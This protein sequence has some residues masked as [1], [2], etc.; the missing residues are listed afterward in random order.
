MTSNTEIVRIWAYNV[1]KSGK[2]YKQI[3]RIIE[4][5]MNKINKAMIYIDD[6]DTDGE[7]ADTMQYYGIKLNILRNVLIDYK[8]KH[9][10]DF[11]PEQFHARP[12]TI[13]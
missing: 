2:E 4:S 1:I 8:A 5:K 6:N 9:D 7:Q 13:G 11:P 12:E 3:I 10:R